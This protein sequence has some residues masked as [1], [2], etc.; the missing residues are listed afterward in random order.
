M[1]EQTAHHS[2]ENMA[3]TP[4][5]NPNGRILWEG[6]SPVDGTPI[7]CILTGL[8]DSSANEKT[9]RMLQT[10]IL[11]KD[12]AP[13]HAI[14]AGLD[15]AIC[16][17]CPHRQWNNV[18]GEL[19]AA[20]GSCYVRAYKAPYAVWNCYANGSGYAPIGDDWG[21]LAGT[22]L[23]MGSYGDPAMIPASIWLQAIGAAATHTGYTHQWRQPFAQDLKGLV[24][25]SC[26]G[27]ADYLESTAHGWK[28]FL[29]KPA[30]TPDPAGMVHCAAS[31]EKG[32]K[33]TC[34]TCHLCDGVSAN[35][36]I[37]AHGAKGKRVVAAN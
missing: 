24:Q 23:R 37:D 15:Y 33:T 21:L 34:V 9:G 28:T 5:T 26:D 35:V 13:H 30:G 22:A 6:F 20:Q 36:V 2:P 10:W 11:R 17:N 8:T 12:I 25:A 4:K 3:T 18:E 29:V 1:G 32:Q 16:G 7:V 31:K 19:I 27:M 14:K